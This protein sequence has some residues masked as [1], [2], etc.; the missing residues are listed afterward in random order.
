MDHRFVTVFY[1]KIVEALSKLEV[2]KVPL[3]LKHLLVSGV[4]K[5]SHNK[6]GREGLFSGAVTER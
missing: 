2:L 5:T 4:A 3:L 6:K 1:G